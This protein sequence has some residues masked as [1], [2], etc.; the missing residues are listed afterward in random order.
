MII[1]YKKTKN[2]IWG[3]AYKKRAQSITISIKDFVYLV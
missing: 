3:T 1:I 2:P